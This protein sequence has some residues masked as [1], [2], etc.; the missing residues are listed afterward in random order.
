VVTALAGA[1]FAGSLPRT[2]SVI[3]ACVALAALIAVVMFRIEA[4]QA[5]LEL[6]SGEAKRARTELERRALASAVE[7]VDP[8]RVG[9]DR[10][11]QDIL[12]GGEVPEYV[13]RDVDG[14]VRDAVEAAL[15]GNGRWLVVVIGPSKVGKSRTLL[16][17]VT[18]CAQSRPLELVA[19]DDADALRASLASA[20]VLTQGPALTV[21]WLDDLEIFLSDGVTL[22]MLR[23]WRSR[24]R[25]GIVVGTYG[26][27][28]S[29]RIAGSTSGGL[30]TIADEVLQSARQIALDA[31]TARE[32]GELPAQ[33]SAEQLALL[34]CHGLAAY[35]VAGPSGT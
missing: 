9:V 13:S 31:T 17:A 22:T 21:L 26:G 18:E 29:E 2:V 30:A 7:E 10:A 6:V 12:P 4:R 25:G 15:D 34:E 19:P 16:E 32:L 3:A 5:G 23:E 14:D 35:L 24:V 28:G 20:D 33:V 27:K 11:A 8:T 1:S